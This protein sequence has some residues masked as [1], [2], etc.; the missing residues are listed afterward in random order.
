LTPLNLLTTFVVAL[1]CQKCWNKPLVWS[2]VLCFVLGVFVEIIG[3]KTGILF[4]GY[5]YGATL[6]PKIWG[7]PLIMGVNWAVLVY[8]SV[9]M[10]NRYLGT[11]KIFLKSLLGA[12]L[13]IANDILIEPIAVAYDFWTWDAEPINFLIVAPLQNYV[14]WW[15]IGFGFN[16]M[17]HLIAPQQQ[18]RIV[19]ILFWLQSVFFLWILL[20]VL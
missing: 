10:M 17:F 16:L 3:V 4:G 5:H 15:I 14:A 13:M 2:L 9:S 12:T 18:N 11:G 19:E 20:I 6:G 8:A 1:Y 7:T